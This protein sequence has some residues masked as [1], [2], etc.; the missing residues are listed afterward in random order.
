MGSPQVAPPSPERTR[1]ISAPRPGCSAAKARKRPPS[2]PAASES[3]GT[4]RNASP[5]KVCESGRAFAASTGA[6]QLA[7]PSLLLDVHNGS[8]PEPSRAPVSVSTHATVNAPGVRRSA[9][10]AT[11]LTYGPNGRADAGDTA[12]GSRAG[13]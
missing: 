3:S 12:T 4:F 2:R 7:P 10:S 13:A 5:A 11:P 8:R 9:V 1:R 6:G